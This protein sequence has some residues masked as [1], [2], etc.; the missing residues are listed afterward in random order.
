MTPHLSAGGLSHTSHP[1]HQGQLHPTSSGQDLVQRGDR[2]SAH[3][4]RWGRTPP[5]PSY[6]YSRQ[7]TPSSTHTPTQAHIAGALPLGTFTPL[8][9][10]PPPHGA[11]CRRS[12]ATRPSPPPTSIPCTPPI[13]YPH[14]RT[15]C[16]AR[17]RERLTR[18]S[19]SMG[20]GLL[21]PLP[22]TL[23]STQPLLVALVPGWVGGGC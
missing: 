9:P 14:T 11:R 16:P 18:H 19:A 10:H 17:P 21:V 22:L 20:G 15:P 12:G 6:H 8:S 13:H 7:G 3:Q 2:L 4:A 1:L 5:P 23:S